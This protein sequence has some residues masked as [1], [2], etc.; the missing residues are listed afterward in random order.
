MFATPWAFL[1]LAAVPIAV[2]IY[3]F[4]MRSR[5]RVVSALFLWVDRQQSQ[6]GGQRIQSPQLPLVLLLE[7]LALSLLAIAAARP[8]FRIEAKSPPTAI[9]LDDSYSMLASRT[10]TESPTD[11]PNAQD[12]PRKRAVLEIERMLDSRI[13]YPIQFIRAGAKPMLI[14]DRA[15]NAAE[16]REILKT[17]KCQSPSADLNAAIAFATN[18]SSIGTKLLVVTDHAPDGKIDEGILLWRSFGESLPNFAITHVSRVF[19]GEKDRLLLEIANQSNAPGRLTMTVVDLK[20]GTIIWRVNE[21]LAAFETH[22]LRTTIPPEIEAI[23][24]RLADDALNIDNRMTIFPPSRKPVRVQIGTLP[25]DLAQKIRRAVETSGLAVLV[26][27]T[28]DI[29]FGTV[30]QSDS[31]SDAAT[32]PASRDTLRRRSQVWSVR[33]AE[34][35][36]QSQ[37][38]PF[39]GPFVIDKSHPL[40]VGLSLDGIIWSGSETPNMLGLPVL[41]AGNVPLIS[42]QILRGGGRTINIQLIERLSTLS[43]GP[44][45]PI[46]IWNILKYRADNNVGFSTNTIKLGGEVTFIAAEGETSVEL[47]TPEGRKSTMQVIGGRVRVLTDSVGV[48]GVKSMTGDFSLGVGTLSADES[49]LLQCNSNTYGNWFTEAV[50][51]DEFQSMVWAVLLGCLLILMIHHYLVSVPAVPVSEPQS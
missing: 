27:E 3:L 25:G 22:R 32:E 36:D 18:I 37:V 12:T 23:E 5:R 16:A 50:L 38:K 21:M 1:A 45:W 6:Q 17:W 44:S 2:G 31:A 13:G 19:Q 29:I 49:N 9:I 4:R 42:E 30:A 40:S 39:I 10:V 11:D 24:V 15:K 51:R 48:Y 46:L 26:S 33:F 7:M 41:S 28:P 47:E 20:R 14:A 8:M 34:T 43:S 35:A